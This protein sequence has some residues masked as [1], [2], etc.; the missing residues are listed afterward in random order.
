MRKW[1]EMSIGQMIDVRPYAFDPNSQ[2]IAKLTVDV[3]FLD[4]KK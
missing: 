4:K 3:D 2:Y 1:A